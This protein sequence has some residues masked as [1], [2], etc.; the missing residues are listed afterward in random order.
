MDIS[1][2][3][4]LK[5]KITRYFFVVMIVLVFLVSGIFILDYATVWIVMILPA[6]SYWLGTYIGL[7]QTIFQFFVFGMALYSY[8]KIVR[9]PPG[10]IPMYWKPTDYTDEELEK[11]KLVSTSKEKSRKSSHKHNT[12]RYCNACDRFK[13]PRAHHCSECNV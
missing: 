8:F 3:K 13:P 4:K 9:T 1:D 10:K 12:P 11:A 2:T 7:A 6:A 5:G